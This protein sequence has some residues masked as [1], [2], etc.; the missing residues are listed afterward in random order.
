MTDINEIDSLKERIARIEK[1][2]QEIQDS[3]GGE[4]AGGKGDGWWGGADEKDKADLSLTAEE[5]EL[6]QNGKKI[7]A[8]KLYHERTGEG[9]KE[10]KDAVDRFAG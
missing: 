6:V 4:A 8:I 1:T 5:A 3:I 7:E 9:L 10:A 2:V